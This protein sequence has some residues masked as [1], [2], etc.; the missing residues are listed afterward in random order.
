MAEPVHLGLTVN[1][2]GHAVEVPAEVTLLDL[3]RERI[4]LTGTKECCA[5]ESAARAP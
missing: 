3:L 4:G 1:G 5:R 2:V